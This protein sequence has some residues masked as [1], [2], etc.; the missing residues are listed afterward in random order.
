[1]TCPLC[2]DAHTIACDIQ[3]FESGAFDVIG[4]RSTGNSTLLW[5]DMRPSKIKRGMKRRK[6]R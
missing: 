4:T 5:I 2:G 6:S 3:A 1:M